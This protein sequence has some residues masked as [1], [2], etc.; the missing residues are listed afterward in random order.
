[1]A[2]AAAEVYKRKHFSGLP[3]KLCMWKVQFC[4][5][6]ELCGGKQLS[7]EVVIL[8]GKMRLFYFVIY[9]F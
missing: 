9:C 1:M 8:K 7:L 2:E 3:G 6:E 5:S 4:T